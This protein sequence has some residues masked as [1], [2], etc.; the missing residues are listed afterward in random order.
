MLEIE[1]INKLDL[2]VSD[3]NRPNSFFRCLQ[4]GFMAL[5][6]VE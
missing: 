2:S 3:K 6:W 4:F 1:A 5:L